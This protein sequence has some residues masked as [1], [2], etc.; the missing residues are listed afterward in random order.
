MLRKK[1]LETRKQLKKNALLKQT[2]N[3]TKSLLDEVKRSPGS[4]DEIKMTVNK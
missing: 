3:L 2:F 4:D 1:L